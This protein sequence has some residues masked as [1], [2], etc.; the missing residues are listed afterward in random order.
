MVKI[1]GKILSFE[2][3]LKEADHQKKR[4]QKYKECFSTEAGQFVIADLISQ[5]S[6]PSYVSGSGMPFHDVT[7]NLGAKS[8]VDEIVNTVQFCNETLL[9]IEKIKTEIMNH[10]RTQQLNASTGITTPKPSTPRSLL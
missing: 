3:G 4:L 1:F 8:V 5:V 7:M 10:E 2:D 6:K 9:L